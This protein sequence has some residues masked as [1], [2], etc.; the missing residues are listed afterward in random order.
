MVRANFVVVG[1]LLLTA[2]CG[3]VEVSQGDPCPVGLDSSAEKK[4]SML[5]AD[6]GP[7][8][9]PT[10]RYERPPQEVCSGWIQVRQARRW[11]WCPRWSR[12]Y[13]VACDQACTDDQCV[14]IG[15]VVA[16]PDPRV[17]ELGAGGI[18]SGDYYCCGYDP[19]VSDAG[20]RVPSAPAAD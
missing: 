7:D 9:T 19:A 15:H 6:S 11:G 14:P 10:S 2:A 20:V 4:T 1:A 5:E 16:N 12:S 17:C 8:V 18:A 3:G 13:V